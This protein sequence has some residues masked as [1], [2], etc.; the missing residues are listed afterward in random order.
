VGLCQKRNGNNEITKYKARLV[1]QG[2]SQRPRIDYVKKYSLVMDVITFRFL[3]SLVVS[4]RL[5]MRLMDV[6]ITYLHGSLDS[7]IYM[8]IPKRFKVTKA[9]NT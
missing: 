9:N 8:K 3:I 1:A 4:Q 7:D 2:F 6:V 5:H